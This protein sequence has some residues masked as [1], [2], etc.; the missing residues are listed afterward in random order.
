MGLGDRHQDTLKGDET[1]IPHQQ[2]HERQVL[3]I[4]PLILAIDHVVEDFAH[5]AVELFNEGAKL[6]GVLGVV[7][8]AAAKLVDLVY[9]LVH[10]VYIFVYRFWAFHFLTSIAALVGDSL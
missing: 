5:H 8:Q 7:I 2:R 9:R 6:L 4:P 10:Q 1:T 3:T